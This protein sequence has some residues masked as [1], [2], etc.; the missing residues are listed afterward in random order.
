MCRLPLAL[1]WLEGSWCTGWQRL[2]YVTHELYTGCQEGLASFWTRLIPAMGPQ[3]QT[4]SVH[5]GWLPLTWRICQCFVNSESDWKKF[6]LL[7]VLFLWHL[8]YC[9][10]ALFFSFDLSHWAWN[11]ILKACLFLLAL[12]LQY[13]PFLFY[14]QYLP[15]LFYIQF[16]QFLSYIGLWWAIL[17]H[18]AP[19]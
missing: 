15:F 4:L 19:L 2:A 10:Q 17:W 18:S 11:T 1:G 9:H 16:F 8:F 3:L 7:R 14:I 5:Q 13:L 6:C 12:N